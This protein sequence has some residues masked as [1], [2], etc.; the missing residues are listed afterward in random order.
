MREAL[1]RSHDGF[2]GRVKRAAASRGVY[3]GGGNRQRRRQSCPVTRMLGDSAG[4]GQR[5]RVVWRFQ[6]V[7]IRHG[8]VLGKR[9][10]RPCEVVDG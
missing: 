9:Q 6:I 2:A 3:Q 8:R 5:V 7:A 4:S 1:V 10:V